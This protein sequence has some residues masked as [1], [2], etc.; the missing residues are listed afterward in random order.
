[1]TLNKIKIIKQGETVIKGGVNSRY[2][3]SPR[4]QTKNRKKGKMVGNRSTRGLKPT[5]FLFH[6]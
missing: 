1:M 2:G 5:T 3:V 6:D 4:D